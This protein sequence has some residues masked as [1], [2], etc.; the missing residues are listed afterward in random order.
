VRE[1]LDE[2]RGELGHQRVELGE[3]VILGANAKLAQLRAER[4]D[5]AERRKD[6]ADL[7]RRRSLPLDVEAADEARRSG[8]ARP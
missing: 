5:V 1:A 3:L 6:L 8:W 7:I 4:G 2:L